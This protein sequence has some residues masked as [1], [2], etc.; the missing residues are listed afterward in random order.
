MIFFILK[1]LVK[2]PS[3]QIILFIVISSNVPTKLNK[4]F[5]LNIFIRKLR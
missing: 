5:L 3:A 2:E 4:N 1:D